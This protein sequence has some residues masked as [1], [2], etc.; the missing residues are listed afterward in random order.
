MRLSARCDC[1]LELPVV[2]FSNITQGKTE[3]VKQILFANTNEM[4]TGGGFGLPWFVGK[5]RIF[6]PWEQTEASTDWASKSN[7]LT[8]RASKL[9]GV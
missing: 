4:V 1:R 8:R 3:Q 9:L 7:Q 2:T 6:S 5:S